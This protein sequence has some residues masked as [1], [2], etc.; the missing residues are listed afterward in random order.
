MQTSFMPAWMAAMKV[1]KDASGDIHVDL[2]SS[3]PCW[4]DESRVLHS[5][6]LFL[7]A[8]LLPY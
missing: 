2:D 3:T 6:S 8:W 5:D 1:R 7:T 4:T